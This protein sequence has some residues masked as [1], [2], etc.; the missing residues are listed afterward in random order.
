[1]NKTKSL[2][3]AALALPLSMQAA[4]LTPQQALQRAQGPLTRAAAEMKLVKTFQSEDGTPT[5]YAFNAPSNEGYLILSADDVAYPVLGYADR[6][7]FDEDNV[8]PTL[9]WWIGEYS[10][11]IA[12]ATANGAK[13]NKSLPTRALGSE[14]K[15]LIKTIWDQGDPFNDECPKVGNV[16]CVTGCVATAM[17]QVMK[18]WEYPEVGKGTVGIKLPSS[19]L[20]DSLDLSAKKFA[21]K[22]MIDSYNEEYTE[23]Q[24]EAVAYLMKA[25]GYAV[26]MSY[27]TSESGALTLNMGQALIKNFGYNHYMTYEQ[28]DNYTIEEWQQLVYDEVA[29][30]RPVLYS[31]QSEGGGHQFICD[32]YDKDGY[33]HFNWGWG[34][35]SDGYF[36]L[37]ALDPNSLGIGGG[38]GGGF[39]YGQDIVA[40]MQPTEMGTAASL[41]ISQNGTLTGNTSS[42]SSIDMSLSN[43]GYWYNANFQPISISL[44]VIIEGTGDVASK[45]AEVTGSWKGSSL[46]L[47][48]LEPGY[49]LTGYTY[50]FPTDFPDGRYKVTVAAKDATS[51]DSKWAP[52]VCP[53]NCSNYCFV[54]KN[55]T[56]Y[57]IEYEPEK[58]A[59]IESAEFLTPL[60]DGEAFKLRFTITNPT[61][62]E[63]TQ[64]VAPGLLKQGEFQ[65]IAMGLPITLKPGETVTRELTSI[66]VKQN[67]TLSSILPSKFSLKFLNLDDGEVF[68]YSQSGVTLEKATSSTV[69]ISNF[70]VKN[71]EVGGKLNNGMDYYVISDPENMDVTVDVTC[72]KGYFGKELYCFLFENG[73][74]SSSNYIIL[75]PIATLNEGETAT[76]GGKFYFG[77]YDPEMIYILS[78][79]YVNGNS[80]SLLDDILTDPDANM[81]VF[82]VDEES[83]VAKV[84]T[85]DGI[86][87]VDYD[88]ASSI[89]KISSGADI[90]SVKAVGIDGKEMN[91]KVDR[92]G[93]TATADLSE[94]PSGIFILV[95]SDADQRAK[96]VK[97]VR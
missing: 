20:T 74:G 62:V 30:K 48:N 27:S 55:G 76:M 34:G 1:M 63:L 24:S 10:R 29:A 41:K 22:D 8:S 13:P 57:A 96:A 28:R 17:A 68:K 89:A 75:S 35:M 85:D 94:L 32:G 37:T 71:S 5:V 92:N 69:S 23:T 88:A 33:F 81:F 79:A 65:Y 84:L 43:D 90:V 49:G 12:Y 51:K 64:T 86:L 40:G 54:T 87:T 11:Q 9:K 67:S 4:T 14:I 39:N 72:E 16:H 19:T 15:P 42:D 66:F 21:W 45:K 60:Y 38:T 26:N 83:G 2:L 3:F 58:I 44:G 73:G 7:S 61:D 50:Q 56:S 93:A 91:I 47:V 46:D 70:T 25:C 52:V 77:D 18:Y 36:L 95:A 80:L 82:I 78:L 97:I 6:G 59:T 53:I 31:G